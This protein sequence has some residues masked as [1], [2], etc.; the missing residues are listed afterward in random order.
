MK[1]LYINPWDMDLSGRFVGPAKKTFSF[2]K[3]LQYYDLEVT[4][5]NNIVKVENQKFRKIK[6]RLPYFA[7][8]DYINYDQ[9][10]IGFDIYYIRFLGGDYKLSSL[11]KKIKKNNPNCKIILELPDIDYMSHY[12]KDLKNIP[13]LLKNYFFKK[14]SRNYIDRIVIMGNDKF[15]NSIPCIKI[16]N[17]IDVENINIRKE[18]KFKRKNEIYFG[19]VASI[20][21]VHGLDLF[22]ESMY[23]Y[24]SNGGE[25]EIYLEIAGGGPELIKLKQLS[26]QLSLENKVHFHGFLYN[27]ELDDF[28]DLI[29][30]G[31]C[32]LA[33]FRRNFTFSSSLKSR[34][35]MA[36]GLPIISGSNIDIF[37]DY[38]FKY[39]HK[40]SIPDKKISM[41]ECIQFYE[42][43]YQKNIEFSDISN[44]IRRYAIQHIDMKKTV[45]P[46]VNYINSINNKK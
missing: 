14:K 33:P 15:I 3:A 12:K 9:S 29:D 41:N 36:K 31:L 2:I 38:P 18:N 23:E 16:Y 7:C 10:F 8:C 21:P 19:C 6:S 17:G 1:V 5:Y 22:M 24:Y 4:L 39:F 43:I 26:K 42:S 45:L 28:Y 27:E 46:I 35:Y 30:I 20:Q 37:M 13:F 34:E 25:R 11:I 32:E 44:E 40:L